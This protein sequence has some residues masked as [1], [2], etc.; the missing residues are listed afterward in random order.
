MTKHKLKMD[1]SYQVIPEVFGVD[2]KIVDKIEM[3]LVKQILLNEVL[4]NGSRVKTAILRDYLDSK[5]FK[6]LGWEPKT[7]N[8]Y[9]VLGF[10]F[11]ASIHKAHQV[12]DLLEQKVEKLF[13]EL[14]KDGTGEA[15]KKALES[16]SNARPGR[17][18][19]K[20]DGIPDGDSPI[21][22]MFEHVR[23]HLTESP[24][25]SKKKSEDELPN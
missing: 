14:D 20:R 22:Q 15:L 23:E 5:E 3:E 6:E 13:S 4:H 8:D 9:F 25:K 12:G 11:L 21:D 16:I 1:E 19:A 2:E 10:A 18:K 7:E 24:L 17:F